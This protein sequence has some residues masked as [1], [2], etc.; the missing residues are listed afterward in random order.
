MGALNTFFNGLTARNTAAAARGVGQLA[1]AG[2]RWELQQRG[3]ITSSSTPGDVAAVEAILAAQMR[4]RVE[5]QVGRPWPYR[6][7]AFFGGIAAGLLLLGTIGSAID[8]QAK[9]GA[10]L[11]QLVLLL[12]VAAISGVAVLV[13]RRREDRR[14]EVLA[15][16]VVRDGVCGWCR[17]P[18]PHVLEGE[19]TE[20]RVYHAIDI[21]R[22]IDPGPR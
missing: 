12:L 10:V 5:Q 2:R 11:L 1:D 22:A 20:P 4:A 13:I 14:S 7:V 15:R 8:K 21:E 9:P 6:K 18:A 16:A 17:E 19:R 3:W